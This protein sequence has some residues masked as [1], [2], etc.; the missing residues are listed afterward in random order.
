MQFFASLDPI[1]EGC[2]GNAQ[3]VVHFRR[4]HE[5]FVPVYAP[6]CLVEELPQVGLMELLGHRVARA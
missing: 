1:I 3:L 4:C 5:S 6:F 2:P